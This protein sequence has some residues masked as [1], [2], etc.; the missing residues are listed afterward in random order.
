MMKNTNVTN[1]FIKIIINIDVIYQFQIIIIK[2]KP[3]QIPIP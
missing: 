3:N 2:T 1:D